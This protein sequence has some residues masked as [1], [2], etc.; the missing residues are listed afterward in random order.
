MWANAGT[1]EK[2]EP[3]EYTVWL[4]PLEARPG[5]GVSYDEVPT[6]PLPRKAD[7]PPASARWAWKV[8]RIPPGDGRPGQV[9]VHVWDC[10]DAPVGAPEV[11]V[12]E[13]LDVLRSV[14]GAYPC[15]E[16]GASIALGPLFDTPE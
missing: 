1:T 6:T 11:D 2:V 12:Y 13:A 10:G 8:Q 9:V 7:E 16:C 4:T 15:K 14:P 5:D 3:H